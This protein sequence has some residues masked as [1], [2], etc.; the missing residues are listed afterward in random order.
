MPEFQVLAGWLLYSPSLF[1][2]VAGT[3]EIVSRGRRKDNQSMV[4]MGRE[5]EAQPWMGSME[6]L[7]TWF[8]LQE[9]EGLLKLNLAL[10]AHSYLLYFT[11]NCRHSLAL[12]VVACMN[13]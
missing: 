2:V 8:H 11:L 10:C 4:T 6:E 9:R 12:L 7:A 13:N 3:K 5:Q 1:L